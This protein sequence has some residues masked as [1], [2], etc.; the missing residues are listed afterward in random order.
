MKEAKC[1][2]TAEVSSNTVFF[3][4]CPLLLCYLVITNIHGD[5][6]VVYKTTGNTDPLSHLPPLPQVAPHT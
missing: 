6:L 5:D 2:D 3:T 4:A 1:Q